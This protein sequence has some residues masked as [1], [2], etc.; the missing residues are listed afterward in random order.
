MTFFILDV[1][2]QFLED[3][4]VR[5]HIKQLFFPCSSQFQFLTSY[6]SL[7]LEFFSCLAGVDPTHQSKLFVCSRNLGSSWS[8]DTFSILYRSSFSFVGQ[9]NTKHFRVG[10]KCLIHSLGR[11]DVLALGFLP[12]GQKNRL[13]W[14]DF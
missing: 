13:E 3:F 9:P 8:S 6:F 2:N 1:S 5:C 7:F 10:K 11:L 14:E 12:E 4:I